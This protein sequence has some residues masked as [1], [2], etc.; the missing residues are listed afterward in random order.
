MGAAISDIFARA[1]IDSRGNPTV[2][3]DCYVDGSLSGRA[4]VPS[5]ASTGT[6]EA[7]ELRDGG[8]RWMGKGVQEAVNNVNGPIREA[9]IGMDPSNQEEIDAL[10]IELDGS[11]N[12]GNLGANA[13]L[14]ASLSCLR[15]ASHG[16]LWNHVCQ[17]GESSLPVPM[18]NILNGGAHAESNVDVQEFMV[19]PHGFKEFSEALRA[20]VEIYHALKSTLKEEGLLGGV[21]DEGGF[22]PNLSRNEEG[23][24]LV[25]EAIERAGYSPGNQV[26][27]ALDVAAQ[28]FFDGTNYHFDGHGI[29]GAEL[30]EIYSKWLDS[31]PI[32]S[33]EDPF[34]EDDWDSWIGFT[35]QEGHR[36]QIVGDDLY[37]TNPKRLEKGISL[38]ASNAILIK[39]N[40]IGTFTETMEVISKS[41]EAG[42]GT[43][44][45]HRSGETS[46]DIIADLAVGTN[47]MQIKTGAPA[48]S[49]RTS[50]YN[51]L[52][53]IS[54][55]VTNYPKLFQ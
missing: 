26:S 45:S 41:R 31:Y 35:S 38:G 55:N 51:Q 34:G 13:T 14:G 6:H 52:L 28:E 1:I 47:S 21:G 44:I 54:E 16:E 8:E 22:A 30:G 24:R 2:E 9:L 23:L 17:S 11:E 5:G 18:M 40:Q 39:L 7:V 49:D 27:I 32:V 36:V 29:S 3:V 46:D 50:K 12:K 33:I 42:F 10:L 19:V 37:V 20:G 43:I 15:A 25:K 4:A 53:R 48:R